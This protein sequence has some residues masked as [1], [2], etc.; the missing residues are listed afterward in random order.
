MGRTRIAKQIKSLGTVQLRAYPD[1]DP[2]ETPPGVVMTNPVFTTTNA[3]RVNRRRFGRSISMDRIESSL[4]SAYHGSMRDITDLSRETIDTDPHLASVLQKRF[5]T[6]ASLP[7][8][9]RPASGPGVDSERAAYYAEVV[10][11]QLAALN[12][13]R[14]NLEQLAWALFDNRAAQEIHWVEMLPGQGMSSD[15]YGFV[16]MAVRALAWIHPRRLSYGPLRELRIQDERVSTGGNFSAAGIALEEIPDKFVWW[17]PQ[18]F[19]EYA[20][21]EGLGQRCLYWSF[22][23]RFSARERMIIAELFTKPWRVLE[24]DPESNASKEDLEDADEIIDN[25]GGSYTARL[26]R[27]TKLNVVQPQAQG[28]AIHEDV[29]KSADAQ[30]SKLVLGQTGTTDGVSAGLNGGSV[31]DGLVNEQLGILT[32]DAA[33]LSELIETQLCDRIISLNFGP[34]AVTHAPVF[35]LRADRPTNRTDELKRLDLAI[36][37]GLPIARDEAYAASGFRIPDADDVVVTVEQP[38]TPPAA[39]N[40]P[41]PRPI[42]VFPQDASPAG[43]EQ[44]PPPAVAAGDAE[45]GQPPAAPLPS[46]DVPVVITVGEA[47]RGAGLPGFGD[48]RDEMTVA[49]F[50]AQGG[51]IDDPGDGVAEDTDALAPSVATFS[52]KWS[53]CKHVY[54]F[55]EMHAELARDDVSASEVYAARREFEFGGCEGHDLPRTEAGYV[56]LVR[57]HAQPTTDLGSPES[58]LDRSQVTTRAIMRKIVEGYTTAVDATGPAPM[59]IFGAVNT[60]ASNVNIFPLA[61]QLE[62]RMLHGFMLGAVDSARQAVT[63]SV[64]EGDEHIETVSDA[65]ITVSI[66]TLLTKVCCAPEPPDFS[67]MNFKTASAFFTEQNVV[68][69]SVF[70]LMSAEAKRRAFTV[71]GVV[72]EQILGTVRS[73]LSRQ[74][75]DGSNLAD[76]SK[77]LKARLTL[78]GF[79]PSTVEIAP[80]VTALSSSHIETVF[81]TNVLNSYNRG[82]ATQQSSATM[83]KLRPVWEIRAVRD[84]RARDTHKNAH[85]TKLL[86]TDPFWRSAYPPFGF[87]CRCRVVTQGAKQLDSVVSGSTIRGLP[88][89]GFTSGIGG[90]L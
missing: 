76:F 75:Q 85:G 78:A 31:M 46:G 45:G 36:K 28:G 12:G 8:E 63:G 32:R 79:L 1:A 62:I 37:A 82:R 57:D 65:E 49:E 73:E 3:Q 9:I 81:R 26:P 84:S 52:R 44:L 53:P 18:L 2:A 16:T 4:L 61:R 13:F 90:S 70:D 80:G 24:V 51:D 68:T 42:M 83:R 35:V 20:E 47:R 72:N 10:R 7:Y 29:I 19:S 67:K 27:G 89:P 71:A 38:P 14:Q 5:G 15:K 77:R 64:E 56:S 43:G 88:D 59:Q 87:N 66:Q 22:F 41:A 21:R 58:I 54:T 60:A 34:G 39:A 86:A 23:K 50:A 30:L 69:R 33:M 11:E 40:P 17:K 55:G 48:E 25:L 6:L 74:I